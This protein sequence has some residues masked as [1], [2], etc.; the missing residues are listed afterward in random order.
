MPE[1][2]I[3]GKNGFL[4]D[5]LKE[6]SLIDRVNELTSLASSKYL[7]MRKEARKTA[8]RFSEENFKKNILNFV[9][10]KV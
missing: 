5:K 7:E 10:S 6:S 1:Y 3:N 4:F 8:E 9:K 2:V